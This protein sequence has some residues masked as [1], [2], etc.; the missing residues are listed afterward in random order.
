MSRIICWFSCGAASAYATKLAI[1]ENEK[2]DNPKELIIASIFINDEHEDSERFKKDCAKWF[3]QE[4]V[5]LKNDK[6]FASVDEV[7]Y[8]TRYMSG[9]SGARCTK[10]LKKQVRYDWQ[11]HDDVHVFGMTCD[12]Q[13]RIDQLID[14]ENEIDLWPI[15]I[16]KN[17]S[18]VDCFD[19]VEK[20][21]IELPVMYQLGYNNNNCRG[22]LKASGAGYWNKTRIDFPEVFNKRADQEKILGVALTK[23]SAN[24]FINKYPEYFKRMMSDFEIGKCKIKIDSRGTMRVPLRYLPPDA[25]KHE[26]IYVG[27]CGFFCEKEK[28]A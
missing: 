10:E 18:K 23:M 21:G 7:I 5:S 25:G 27:D 4:I 11:R 26:S 8:K 9:P 14:S 1:E 2:R 20:A 19:A 13:D 15:L 17:I 12:E 3:G 28:V 16:D 24:K 6:Y 22:C